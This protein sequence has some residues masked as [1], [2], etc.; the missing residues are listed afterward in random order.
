MGTKRNITMGSTEDTVKIVSA[1]PDASVEGEAMA[2]TESTE[3]KKTKQTGP[4]RSRRYAT[5]RAHVDKTKEYDAFAAVELVKKL[6]YSKFAGTITADALVKDPGMQ[7]SITFPHSVGKQVRVAIVNEQV[8]KD[9]EAGVLD[10]DI[11]VTEARFMPQLAKFARVLGPKGLMPNPKNG[12]VTANPE[13]KKQELEGG[14]ITLKGEKK[15]P[16]MHVN[17]GKTDMTSEA[18]V[19]NIQ[20]LTNALKGKILKL[21]ISATM[22]PGVRVVVE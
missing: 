17:I 10:F 6:S 7:I 19:A 18:L 1:N 2:S 4:R 20:A 8:L 9:I 11:L 21:S 3:S 16:L 13:L 5:V 22:S 14:K 12:T 15:A